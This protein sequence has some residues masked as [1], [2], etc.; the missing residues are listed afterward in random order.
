MTSLALPCFHFLLFEEAIRPM[1][2]HEAGP[3]Q[4]PRHRSWLQILDA[5]TEVMGPYSIFG[6]K[7]GSHQ[8]TKLTH[9]QD[10]LECSSK[11]SN[12]FLFYIA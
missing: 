8:T 9:K 1:G 2:G 4:T 11:P 3:Y 6:Y 10:I 5:N 12:H 7:G